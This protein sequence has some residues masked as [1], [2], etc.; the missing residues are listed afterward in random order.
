MIWIEV[1]SRHRDVVA[2][3]RCDGPEAFVGR[4]YDNDVVVD[5]PFVAPRH[6]RVF[7]DESGALIAEDLRTVN[8]TF[9]ADSG[10][11]VSRATIDGQRPLRIG[12]TLLRIRDAAYAVAPERPS[13][14]T[15]NGWHRALPLAFVAFAVFAMSQWLDETTEFRWASYLLPL[16]SLAFMLLAWTTGW[17][18]LSRLF[19][20]AAH[21]ERHLTIALS[22]FLA[23]YAW[24][25]FA[26]Y[27]AFA[28][29]WRGVG[30][31]AFVGG[32]LV[33]AGMCYF[34][35]RE[36]GPRH[37]WR[38][39]ATLG[40]LALVGIGAQTLMQVEMRSWISQQAGLSDLKPP[41]FRLAEP[42]D[43][44]AFFSAAELLKP[45][46][47]RARTEEPTSGSLPSMFDFDE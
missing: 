35:L 18:L 42:R 28:L 24:E 45:R 7:R 26:E 27:V 1:L 9:E 46:L 25:L 11:S 34:H 29:A 33:V 19:T 10:R 13:I 44:T 31:F 4:G 32:W 30:D 6:L 8:G 37:L 40:A 21:F 36:L 20:G 47:D 12:R 38:K 22:G 43:A 15:G 5:D 39:A 3:H 23:W 41:F 14:T 2:R 16:V 17:A